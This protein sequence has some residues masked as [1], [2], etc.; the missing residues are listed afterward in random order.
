ML[1]LWDP[2]EFLGLLLCFGCIF[3]IEIIGYVLDAFLVAGVVG[4]AGFAG[5]LG[6]MFWMQFYVLGFY[7][8]KIRIIN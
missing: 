7:P 5:V 6:V 8:G 4:F 3:P 2:L 1:E